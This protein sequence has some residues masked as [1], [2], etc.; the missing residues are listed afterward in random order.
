MEH[1]IELYSRTTLNLAA[2]FSDVKILK[3]NSSRWSIV[4]N[5]YRNFIMA[6]ERYVCLVSPLSM[7]YLL[8]MF[9]NESYAKTFGRKIF[10]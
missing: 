3:K 5:D 1:K 2:F 8:M 10:C 9:R 4:I 6:K 7:N